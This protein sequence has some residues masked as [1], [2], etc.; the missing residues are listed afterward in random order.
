MVTK[1]DSAWAGIARKTSTGTFR[2]WISDTE[3]QAVRSLPGVS[4]LA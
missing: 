3:E 2:E 4:L 1:T